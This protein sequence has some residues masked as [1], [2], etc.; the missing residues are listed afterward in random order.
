MLMYG[1]IAESITNLLF[2][3]K[4]FIWARRTT[5][6]LLILIYFKIPSMYVSILWCLSSILPFCS[7]F[8]GDRAVLYS[9]AWHLLA[10]KKLLFSKFW[11]HRNAWICESGHTDF[12]VD[13]PNNQGMHENE[14]KRSLALVHSVVVDLLY[15]YSSSASCLAAALLSM[16]RD[17]GPEVTV[18]LIVHSSIN[19]YTL[20]IPWPYSDNKPILC[21]WHFLHIHNIPDSI[22]YTYSFPSNF[23]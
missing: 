17:E 9:Q 15:I 10:S 3:C 20:S 14:R 22:K 5:V 16:N 1:V 13:S 19:Y 18:T 11:F 12:H 23:A 8:L 4:S 2:K 21:H 7:S 6:Q